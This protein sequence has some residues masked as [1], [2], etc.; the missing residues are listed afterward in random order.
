MSEKLIGCFHVLDIWSTE[1]LTAWRLCAVFTL[2][3]LD[4]ISNI[5]TEKPTLLSFIFQRNLI[6]ILS[7]QTNEYCDLFLMLP[8]KKEIYS[9]NYDYYSSIVMIKAEA[10]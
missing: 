10:D 6:E 8:F 7:N 1:R 3:A 2:E 5:T 9:Y 4:L